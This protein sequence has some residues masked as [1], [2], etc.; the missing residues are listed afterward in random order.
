M[1]DNTHIDLH[2]ELMDAAD[3]WQPLPATVIELTSAASRPDVEI[4]EIARI[5]RAD[6][7]LVVA[8]L[9]ESNSAASQT[10]REIG[11]VEEAIV[12][13]GIGRVVA[14]AMKD[15]LQPTTERPLP[16]YGLRAGE[17]W[18][19]CLAAMTVSEQVRRLSA[20]HLPP[21]LLT[22]ALLH[23]IGKVVLAPSVR[24]TH[25]TA[26]IADHGDGARAE[27]V[28]LGVDHAATGGYLARHWQLPEPL[29]VAIESHHLLDG[30]EGPLAHAI[31]VADMVAHRLVYPWTEPADDEP[32]LA[33]AL[34]TLGLAEETLMHRARVALEREGFLVDDA[35]RG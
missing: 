10:A 4:D 17:M 25:L 5:A 31:H 35:D 22:A 6:A 23:D 1:L 33:A 15:V 3:R 34:D 8:L 2:H 28:L 12:R 20:V 29:C 14:L 16:G 27:R 11:T 18:N 9:R 32:T 7:A 30:G 26:A 13:L 24:Y 21:N 19:H